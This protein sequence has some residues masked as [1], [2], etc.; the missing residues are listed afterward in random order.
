[1]VDPYAGHSWASGTA[2]FADGNNQESS[3]E[4]VNAWNGL[5]LWAAASGQKALGTE[6]S[7]LASNE[8][9]DARTYWTQTKLPQGFGHQV[10]SLNWGGKRDWAT[11]FSPDPNA[12]LAIQLIP[13]GPVQ[14]YLGGDPARI[15]AQVKEATPGGTDVQFGGYLLAY[16]ALAGKADA[17]QAWTAAQH[18]SDTAID[19]ASSHAATLAFIASAA[20]R[21]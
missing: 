1:M 16:S 7:W 4:A 14:S 19:D 21:S 3:A 17:D 8:A 13:M 18:L 6:A 2:P 11:W 9:N 12:I 15:R 5:G 10:V 20:A